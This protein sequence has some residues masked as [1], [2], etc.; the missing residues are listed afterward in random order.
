MP[1]GVR[2][3]E[4]LLY[5]LPRSYPFVK[6]WHVVLTCTYIVCMCVMFYHGDVIGG[7]A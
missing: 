1:R 4:V 2:I 3:I 6:P 5:P 7:I